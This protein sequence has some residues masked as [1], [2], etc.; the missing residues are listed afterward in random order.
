MSLTEFVY[1]G[2]VGLRGLERTRYV[3][4]SP[5]WFRLCD[6]ILGWFCRDIH[7]REVQIARLSK[8]LNQ[9]T[10]EAVRIHRYL[11]A[12]ERAGEI[13]FTE[14]LQLSGIHAPY[15]EKREQELKQYS[16]TTLA[17]SECYLFDMPDEDFTSLQLLPAR[18]VGTHDL[19]RVP[20]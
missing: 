6:S 20:A 11:V 1:R 4:G 19:R 8:K 7:S 3:F 16:G 10:N 14:A 13:S 2:F 9:A 5:L 15:K 18:I 17:S 12:A